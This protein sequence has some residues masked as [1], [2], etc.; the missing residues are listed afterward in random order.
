METSKQYDGHKIDS[1]L[2]LLH[3]KNL[4]FYLKSYEKPLDGW[5]SSTGMGPA[6]SQLCHTPFPQSTLPRLAPLSSLNQDSPLPHTFAASSV[7][8]LSPN[9]RWFTLQI[10]FLRKPSPT[11]RWGQYLFIGSQGRVL[12]PQ[13]THFSLQVYTP[14][15]DYLINV[16]LPQGDNKLQKNK[17]FCS[18]FVF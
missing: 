11:P 16:C 17:Y 14:F 9:Q 10:L 1:E 7:P 2:G 5:A 18:Y 8:A 13:G 4:E 3:G 12:C 15:C 6:V